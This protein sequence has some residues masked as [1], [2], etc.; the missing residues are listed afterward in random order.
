MGI[1]KLIDELSQSDHEI[2]LDLIKEAYEY[3]KAKHAGQKRLSG[4]DYIS[5]PVEVATI[6]ADLG[7]DDQTIAASL[8]HDV[9][10]DTPTTNADLV[11]KFGQ[12]VTELVD[13]VTKLGTVDFSKLP[14]ESVQETKHKQEI[15]NLR[16]LFLAMAKDVR[17]V[18]IKLADRL[19]NMRTIEYLSE[20]NQKR[21]SRETLEIFAPL[22]D[23]L[24][25][26]AIKSELE[27]LSFKY[28]EPKEYK[29]MAE[30]V[31]STK[32][33]RLHYLKKANKFIKTELEKEGIESEIDGR[34]K[35]LFSIYNKLQKVNN[36]V[37]KI[38]DLLAI[39][40]IVDS[41]E[42]CYKALGIVHKHFKPLIYRIKDYI[43]VPKPNGYQ[44]LHTTVFGFEGKITEIQIRTQA[45][46][47]E[48][49]H[50][51]AAHWYYNES[52]KTNAYRGVISK[53]PTDRM[54]WVNKIMDWQ[55]SVSSNKEFAEALKIDL[56]NDRIFVFSPRGDVF[57]LPEGATPVDFAY[58]VHSQ[59]GDRCRGAKVNDKLVQLD[60]KLENRDVVEV[61]LASKNDKSGPS[62][63]WLDF[64]KTSK[65]K[66]HIRSF[67]KKLNWDENVDA[68]RKLLVSELVMFGMV[69][70][71]FST[72][73]TRQLLREGP[74][75]S[76]EEV[77]VSIGDGSISARQILKKIIGQQIY[78][79]VEKPAKPAEEP[80]KETE[81]Y[82]NLSGIL[83][84][85]AACCKPKSGDKVK[86]FIT[87]GLGIT[88]HREDCPNLLAS[89]PEKV[90]NI[91]F[92]VV[93]PTR[94]S[95]Q[96]HGKNRV[97]FIHDI[98]AVISEDK[99]NISNIRNEHDGEMS[100]IYLDVSVTST[101][102]I[103]DLMHKIGKVEGVETVK[104]Q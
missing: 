14:E 47:E 77:L 67:L 84:R 64:V 22:A 43:A 73:E 50:G 7:V 45:M 40:I 9:L 36:D 95:I 93:E 78:V 19:H 74:W 99:V 56:F 39:R 13:G 29:K 11:K 69:E 53:T 100:T 92:E 15:E 103:A 58:E 31:E 1:E 51:V 72:E 21:I 27:D 32:K 70:S 46:H 8:L 25:M 55:N 104:K 52:K 62:R 2:D 37:S 88:I 102:R 97:G 23:R 28:L 63:G 86:G 48:A 61:V 85:Y 91:D 33:E 76:W 44:S 89:P 80:T 10:E 87:R 54:S 79:K 17:V 16:K 96:I 83:V 82:S 81:A 94:F 60:Y 98:T 49:E 59:I 66:Q 3:A 20:E 71:D 12:K 101:E 42:D 26:G 6:L 5:H 24:G 75:K 41:V 30:I 35:H 4:E 34:V 90:I 18:I 57:D 38:Y 65:A 68:G